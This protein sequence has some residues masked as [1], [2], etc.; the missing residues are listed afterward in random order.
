MHMS[1]V[2]LPVARLLHVDTPP[3]P[4]DEPCGA[5]ARGLASWVV[6]TAGTVSCARPRGHDG[7]HLSEPRSR[8]FRGRGSS[9]GYCYRW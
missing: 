9:G 1:I 3:E 5:L 6:L 8:I 7:P 2:P 4:A